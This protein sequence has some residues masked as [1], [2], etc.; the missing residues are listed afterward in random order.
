[1]SGGAGGLGLFGTQFATMSD[2]R[3]SPS[4]GIMKKIQCASTLGALALLLS[5][6][7][8]L[9]AQ[10]STPSQPTDPTAQQPAQ[11]SQG[12]GSQ[13]PN[14]RQT[15]DAASQAPT[16]SQTFTGTIVKSG[17]KYVLQDTASGT[18]YDV[19]H[20]DQLKQYEGRKVRVRGTL[21]PSSKMI[22]LQ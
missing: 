9:S 6:G 8:P 4:G 12:T 1:M 15:P 11:P 21:D 22:H 13:T 19:D 14:A 3:I 10:Q 17:D 18:A 16:D 2:K 20:Q 7:L 5:L